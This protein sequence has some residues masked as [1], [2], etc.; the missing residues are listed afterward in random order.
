MTS[1]APLQWDRKEIDE[2]T[3]ESIARCSSEQFGAFIWSIAIVMIVPTI[4]TAFVSSE[5]LCALLS[6]L[7]DS[8]CPCRQSIAPTSLTPIPRSTCALQMAWKTNDVDDALSESSWI[9]TMVV[10][11]L[12]VSVSTHHNETIY[13]I[14]RGACSWILTTCIVALPMSTR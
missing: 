13:W 7:K 8:E 14:H 11:Q 9:F 3:G 10:V 2:F 12:A 4:L 1:V 5:G 6:C